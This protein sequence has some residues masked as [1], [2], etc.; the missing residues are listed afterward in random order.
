MFALAAPRA[1]PATT[2]EKKQ[3]AKKMIELPVRFDANFVT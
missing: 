1:E 3:R 2:F